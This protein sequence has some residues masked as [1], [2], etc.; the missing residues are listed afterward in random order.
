M[1]LEVNIAIHRLYLGDVVNKTCII[2]R[3]LSASLH[4]FGPFGNLS[5]PLTVQIQEVQLY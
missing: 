2:A 3:P 5:A 4:L 1:M